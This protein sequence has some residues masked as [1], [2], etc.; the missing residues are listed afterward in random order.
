M[1]VVIPTYSRT[2]I[3]QNMGHSNYTRSK[4]RIYTIKA[5]FFAIHFEI[6]TRYRGL[7]MLRLRILRVN[8]RR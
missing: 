5:R 3:Y 8:V 1:Y 7:R 2:F 4:V 6:A